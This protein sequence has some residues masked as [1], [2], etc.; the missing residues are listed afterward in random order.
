MAKVTRLLAEL[1]AL[2]SVNSAF[3]PPRHQHAG[4][5]RVAEYLAALGAQAGLDIEFQKVL[6]G[7]PNVLV[8]FRPPGK[9][10]QTI[11][12]APHLDTVNV[13]S[14]AQLKPVQRSGRLY[15]RGACDT[16][17]S[18][19]VMFQALCDLAGGKQRPRETE[20]IFVGLVDEENGQSGSR[21]LAAQGFKADLAIVGEPTR[22]VLATAHKGSVWLEVETRGRAA[23]GATPW[24]GD[25]AVQAM[26]GVVEAL[27]T[28][29]AAQLKKKKHP[30]LG[31]GTVSVGTIRGGTQTNIV[32][33]NCLISVDRRTLPGESE[34]QTRQALGTFLKSRQLNAKVSNVKLKPCPALET[35]ARLP[36]VKQFLGSIGQKRAV[37]L[38]YFCDAAVLASG[39]I[40][41]VV[42]GPGD[43]AQAH[44]ADEWIEIS[45]LEQGR[46]M[47][48]SFLKS[49]P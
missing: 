23:H 43:I 22:L 35:D 9:I 47:L 16:K 29:Y 45:Q 10:R 8:R 2:P 5:G 11:L 4:E 37:G 18:V 24:F 21:H 17:G 26:A 49:L 7:R 48:L 32:P 25:N 13:V 39:G 46:A 14:D 42:F 1:I 27:Q 33:D 40:P 20:I 41:S 28:D 6:P 44:T 30:L 38:H 34:A 15:G 3:L 12:L 19:A 31:H 36:L